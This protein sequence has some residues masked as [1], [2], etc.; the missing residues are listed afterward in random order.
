M[1]LKCENWLFF[2]TLQNGG[3]RTEQRAVAGLLAI[4]ALETHKLTPGANL[5]RHDSQ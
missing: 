5:R 4:D 2:K 1:V 3:P